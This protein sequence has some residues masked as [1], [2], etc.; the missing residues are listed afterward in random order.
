M[1]FFFLPGLSFTVSFIDRAEDFNPNNA[2]RPYPFSCS[3]INGSNLLICA[4]N[5]SSSSSSSSPGA[6]TT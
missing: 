3:L 6:F 4:S 1:S 2:S 5:F